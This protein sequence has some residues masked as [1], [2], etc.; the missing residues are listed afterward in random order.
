MKMCE[1]EELL[2]NA[3]YVCIKCGVVLGQRIRPRRNIF[4][5]II[6]VIVETLTF[7]QLFVLF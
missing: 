1:Q 4:P 6:T 7:M 2:T 5:I 3:G